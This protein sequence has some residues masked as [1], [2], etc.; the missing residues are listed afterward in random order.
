MAIF[1]Q[2]IPVITTV[3]SALSC[4]SSRTWGTAATRNWNRRSTQMPAD[5]IDFLRLFA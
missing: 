5:K 3:L 1:L 4:T 2:P